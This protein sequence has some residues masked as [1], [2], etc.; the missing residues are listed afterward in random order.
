[1]TLKNLLEGGE[2]IDNRDF[3]DRVDLLERR[4]ASPVLGPTTASSTAWRTTSRGTRP[5]RSAWSTSAHPPARSSSEKYYTYLAGILLEP[6]GRLFKN[7]PR[8]YTYPFREPNTK[9]V[10]TA[11]NLRVA[12]KLQHLYDYLIENQH[13]QPIRD[14]YPEN[15]TTFSR[16]VFRRM[17]EGDPSWVHDVPPGVA[18]L[19]CQRQL[20]GFDPAKF[21]DATEVS[22]KT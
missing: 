3:L 22:T 17:Q 13:I 19:I 11:G 14:Y 4:S 2:T 5:S 10:I 1:M 20:L 7:D 15:L 6:F 9:A 8:V 16:E 18:I 12:P 21:E